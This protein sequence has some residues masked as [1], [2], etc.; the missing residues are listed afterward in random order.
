[1]KHTAI[2]NFI[3]TIPAMISL[4]LIAYIKLQQRTA[5]GSLMLS[6]PRDSGPLIA[7]L[8]IFTVGYLLFLFMIFFEDIKNSIS[9]KKP[10][11]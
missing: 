11:K 8:I 5:L 9:A 7:S 6:P 3:L 2:R 1:M 4:G 10:A